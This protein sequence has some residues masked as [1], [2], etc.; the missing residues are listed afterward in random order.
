[1]RSIQIKH[2]ALQINSSQLNI[3][4]YLH[5]MR[6][7]PRRRDAIPRSPQRF[8]GSG[9]PPR[10]TRRT[11]RERYGH[12]NREVRR[13]HYKFV[14]VPADTPSLERLKPSKSEWDV[15][16]H[17]FEQ[18]SA[19]QAKDS[20]LFPGPGSKVNFDFDPEYIKRAISKDSHMYASVSLKNSKLDPTHSHTACTLVLKDIKFTDYP[21]RMIQES[22]QDY[23]A[24]TV[25][26]GVESS[27][28]DLKFVMLDDHKSAVVT[29]KNS[30]VATVLLSL[31]GIT[32]PSIGT[33]LTFE[34]PHEYISYEKSANIDDIIPRIV[35]SSKLICVRKIP[36]GTEK[37]EIQ[38][39]LEKYGKLKSFVVLLD[40]VTFES[41][42]IAFCTYK[43]V[44]KDVTGKI[45]DEEVGGQKLN[46]IR[47]CENGT[48]HYTQN[49]DLDYVSLL[50][51]AS[52]KGISSHENSNVI[53]FI[54]CV[55]LDDLLD[56][57]KMAQIEE[58]FKAA[59]EKHGKVIQF[60]IS[61]PMRGFKRGLDQLKPEY[62]F[63][64]VM[65]NSKEEASRCLYSLAGK[66]FN[67]RLVIGSFMD[68]DD[69]R[70]GLL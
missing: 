38:K 25:I 5:L 35:Q 33:E 6:Y 3:T 62:G 58:S 29:T 47:P 42:G 24:S 41:K 49:V 37:T 34:R 22:L 11:G 66:M 18:V 48:N 43:D 52:Q 13:H 61:K 63:I 31:S 9:Y 68:E 57:T 20:G 54:N 39:V 51:V 40:K 60:Q 36:F 30:V 46:C 4:D 27:D 56:D 10:S 1:M 15:K 65:F 59:C 17:G 26:P 19:I 69:Y 23:L 67:D 50:G 53:R 28:F 55:S 64:Y 44:Q 16:P 21:I 2:T 14:E 70:K 8:R 12:N 45:S 32:I 7:Q